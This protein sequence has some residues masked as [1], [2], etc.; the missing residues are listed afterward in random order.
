LIIIINLYIKVEVRRNQR[1][2]EILE[3]LRSIASHRDLRKHDC[4]TVIILSHGNSGQIIASDNSALEFEKVLTIFNNQNC[5]QLIKKPKMFFF[6]C[7]R[8]STLDFGPQFTI[9]AANEEDRD[10]VD[11]TLWP[12]VPIISDMMICYSTIDGYV[13][14]RN[15]QNGTWFGS[16]LA[17]ALE[18]NAHSLEL[19]QILTIASDIV[20]NR[21]T[22]NGA[23]QAIEWKYRAW[24][25]SL[26]FNPNFF[27]QQ[28][29]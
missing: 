21:T 19:N 17:N 7:C 2:N 15:E 3:T 13:S 1:R 24:T 6:N 25:K 28:N 16:A 10:V 14:W 11:A 8:G 12:Q 26:Y 23:K 27:K 9:S 29:N 5:H 22:K 18:N 20:H 4:L